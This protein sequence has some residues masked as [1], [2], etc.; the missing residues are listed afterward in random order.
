MSVEMECPARFRNDIEERTF[1]FALRILK[2]VKALPK[3][4][5]AQAIARQIIRSGTGIG[6]NV[7]EAQ[8][9]QTRKAFARKMNIARGESLETRYWLRLIAESKMFP[10]E[11]IALLV[12]EADELVR[13][14]TTIVKNTRSNTSK[15]EKRRKSD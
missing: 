11:R 1:Q 7:E 13:I 10:R 4:A 6:G 12:Q 5:A 2:L 3:D 14:I 8:G 9:S 15:N